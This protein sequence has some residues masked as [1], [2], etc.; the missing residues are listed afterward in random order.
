MAAQLGKLPAQFMRKVVFERLGASSSRTLV[1]PRFGV[2]NAVVQVGRGKVMIATTDPL[3]FIPTL[4]PH[5]SAWL[6]VHL[7]ASDLT[8]SGLSPQY[9][10]FDFNLPPRMQ[11]STFAAY[12]KWFH[13]EWRRLGLAIVGGHTGRFYGCD[14]T[15][16]GAGVI[17]AIG[18]ERTYVSSHMGRD[19]DDII[20]T[21]GL[22]IGTTAVL[23]RTF[24]R[25]LEKL[26]GE[27]LFRKAWNYLSKMSTV[28]DALTAVT[29]GIRGEG[30][31]AMHDATEGGV[32][33]A[34]VE[35]V[36]ASR[37]GAVVDLEALPVSEE[38]SAICK[39]FRINP[40]SSLSEGSLIIA[41]RPSKTSK[42]LRR[43]SSKGIEAR[44]VGKLTR[45]LHGC[46]ERTQR[47]SRPLR[48]PSV[49]DY[50][51]AYWKGVKS[52]WK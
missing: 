13:E 52:G 9:G 10:I 38:T 3:S 11:D 35:L 25:T 48:Y 26:L 5:H 47:G 27:N 42:I 36:D 40:R 1:G 41:S 29:V 34:L 20:L 8:T 31:T 39:L 15:I 46:Y 28:E 45:R 44:V 6:S 7:L 37:L 23:A 21:K 4:G 17:W 19:G 24:P 18:P 50:W 43:L 16:I 22:A 30:V 51:K 14:Y 32:L 12:W 2:D 33:A 49:D